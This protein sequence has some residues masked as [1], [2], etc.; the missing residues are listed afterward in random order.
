MRFRVRRAVP[1]DAAAINGVARITWA[2]T[3]RGI[4]P[5][6]IQRA[7]LPLWY[8]EDRLARA[9]ANPAGAFFVAE[10]E[11]G[12]VVGFAQ[13]GRREQAGDA[14][15]WRFYVLP[16]HQ[17]KGIGRQL[18]KACVE[19]L[20]EGGDVA[21]LFVQVEAE[22]QIGRRA[23][24]ALGFAYVREYEDDLMGHVSRMCEMCLHLHGRPD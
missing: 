11:D 5:D 18:L 16:E 21:R 3:Y 12:R 22:N 8:A 4:I 17:R 13:A 9:A 1:E 15:L 7:V 24:E 6:E 20:Q 2:E 14:E 19:S 23:Y 10:S